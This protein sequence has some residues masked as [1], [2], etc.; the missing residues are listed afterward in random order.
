MNNP[1]YPTGL[2]LKYFQFAVLCLSFMLACVSV[3]ACLLG[4][5]ATEFPNAPTWLLQSFATFPAIGGIIA[6]FIGGAAATK[7]GKKNLCLLGIALCFVGGFGAMLVPSL[8]GKIAI[9][10]LAGLGVGLI[11]PLSAS[12]IIDCFDGETANVMMGIQSAFVGLGATIYSSTMAAI[13]VY[14]W[15][16]AY[17]AYLYCVAFFLIVLT[18]VPAFVN[19]IGREEKRL[20]DSAAPKE[21]KKLP[22]SSYVGMVSQF[23]YAIGYGMLA[24][25]LSLAAVE[26]GISTTTAAFIS[27][28][29]GV[30]SLIG[31][32]I[33]GYVLKLIPLKYMGPVAL[34]L[35]ICG[36]LVIGTTASIP[37]WFVGACVTSL[38]FSWWMPYVNFIVNDG[39]DETNSAMATAMG[40]AGNSAGSFVCAY[41]FAAVGAVLGGLTQHQ[42]FLFGAAFIASAFA[43]ILVYTVAHK[44]TAKA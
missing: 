42:G 38:G 32:L 40:F 8:I 31:G 21:A 39:T 36:M 23:I 33:F 44:S 9:R 22:G 25:C 16:F 18:G 7:I 4:D 11:Q 19:Q 28:V 20:D 6:N 12:L 3:A 43:I 37:L 1:N 13:M 17:C 35:N 41:V 5:L 27:T 24:A 30:A 10:C 29:S 15:H 14:D 26:V 2:R 34:I